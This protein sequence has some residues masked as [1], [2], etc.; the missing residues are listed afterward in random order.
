LLWAWHN[1]TGQV[2]PGGL[3]NRVIGEECYVESVDYIGPLEKYGD[4]LLGSHGPGKRRGVSGTAAGGGVN[5]AD[6][7]G[8]RMNG[9]R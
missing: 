5:E 8:C 7:P 6:C 4:S 1:R 9:G 2:K 3:E